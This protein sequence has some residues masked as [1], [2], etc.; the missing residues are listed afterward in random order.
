MT[1]ARDVANIDGI[2]T[3]TGDTFYASAAGTPAR[4]GIGTTGQVMTVAAGV[5]SWATPTASTPTFVGCSL[6]SSG[7]VS[8][9]NNTSTAMTFDSE[10]FDTDGFHSTSSNTTRITIPTG[11]SGYYLVTG[12]I[13]FLAGS[14]TGMRSINLIKNGTGNELT[15][16]QVPNSAGQ[17]NES[18]AFSYTGNFT[19]GDYLEI[20]GYHNSGAALNMRGSA[21]YT[22]FSVSYL[23]V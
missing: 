23:G 22:R 19:A 3:T 12:M 16:D 17:V 10:L 5:P 11:K 13:V 7:S 4:L 1:R 8:A 20:Y 15:I 2:L 9:A 6:W 18:P 14:S 21:Y